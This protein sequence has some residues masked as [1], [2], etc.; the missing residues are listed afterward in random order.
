MNTVGATT[1]RPLK[2]AP[3]GAQLR[4]LCTMCV[5]TTVASATSWAKAELL[6]IAV[7]DIRPNMLRVTSA[8]TVAA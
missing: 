4:W 2:R 5:L 6:A 7:V 8:A 1:G 3:S